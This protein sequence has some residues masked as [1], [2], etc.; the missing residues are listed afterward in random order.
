M[1][2]TLN[3]PG[4]TIAAVATATGVGG[5][6]VVRLSGPEALGIGERG[7]RLGT[8]LSEAPSHSAHVGHFVDAQGLQIDEVVATVFRGPSSYTGEDVVEISCHGGSLIGHRIAELLVEYGARLAEPGEFTKRAF[9]NGRIDLAQAEAVAELIHARSEMARRTSLDQLSGGISKK[10]GALR[11]SLVSMLGLLELELDFVEEGIELADKTMLDEKITKSIRE[12]DGLVSSYAAGKLVREGVRVV[13]AGSPNVG[14]SS[15]L[16]AMLKEDRAIVTEIPGTTRDVI[17]EA[18]SIGGIHFVL[19]DTAGVRAT[20]D[21]VEQQ[22]LEKTEQKIRNSDIALLVFDGSREIEEHELKLLGRLIADLEASATPCIVVMNKSDLEES[23]ANTQRIGSI[24][25]KFPN[26]RIS[27]KTGQ[28]LKE[29]EKAM[30]EAA[31][32]G[33]METSEAGLIV[34]NQRHKEALSRARRSLGLAQ[35]ALR[36]QKSPEFIALDLRQGLDCL[37]EII[38]VTTTE[39]ILNSIFSKFCIGK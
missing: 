33:M 31:R 26:L 36:L 12:L 1:G 30:V 13:L 21:V 27:A 18:I 35:E 4:D 19:S 39:D 15:I 8:K 17:E 37:G 6:A 9:L 25:D 29:L 16:N 23:K 10:V 11:D 34:T 7:L 20:I 38:G 24:L 32:L 14:K 28:G 3:R 2:A 22:G 5:I